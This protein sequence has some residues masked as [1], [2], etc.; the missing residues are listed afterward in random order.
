MLAVVWCGGRRVNEEIIH[1]GHA[2]I[3]QRFCRQSEFGD[4]PWA[5]ALGC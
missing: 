1:A 2:R 5:V 4:Q 3:Y